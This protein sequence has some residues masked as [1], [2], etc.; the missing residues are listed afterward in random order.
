MKSV[1]LVDDDG[2]IL[3][4]LSLALAPEFEV[5][6][7]SDGPEAL[8]K[9]ALRSYDAVALD[10]MMP[11]LDGLTVARR[12]RAR[13]DRTAIILMSASHD[14]EERS[15][16]IPI[17]EYLKKLFTPEELVVKLRRIA[18]GSG[19]SGPPPEGE[20]PSNAAEASHSE[21]AHRRTRSLQWA[22]TVTRTLR[23]RRE[24]E[25]TAPALP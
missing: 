19:S 16:G 14:I 25:L 8:E 5:D 12:L 3:F 20:E 13:G 1:L 9:L 18:S 23:V 11:S 4:T 2:D 7:A 21:E 10:V 17:L 22:N 15:K 24:R 6:Q